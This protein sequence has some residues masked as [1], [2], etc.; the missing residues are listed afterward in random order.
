MSSVASPVSPLP[1]FPFLLAS[2][3]LQLLDRRRWWQRHA[4]HVPVSALAVEAKHRHVLQ[5][6][7]Q[8][9]LVVGHGRYVALITMMMMV[10]MM[11]NIGVYQTGSKHEYWSRKKHAGGIEVRQVPF[12]IFCRYPPLWSHRFI[13]SLFRF[14]L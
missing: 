2:K 13:V 14:L 11:N 3:D 1:F 8:G 4:E 12:I 6:P 9:G 7:R 10:M 5:R